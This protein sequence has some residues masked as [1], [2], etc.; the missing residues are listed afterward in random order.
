MEVSCNENNSL[1][2]QI[3]G[4]V[5]QVPD[6]GKLHNLNATMSLYTIVRW[7]GVR[8]SIFLRVSLYVDD[9]RGV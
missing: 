6:I 2:N 7:R 3:V 4:C 1:Q 5:F 9:G 8:R